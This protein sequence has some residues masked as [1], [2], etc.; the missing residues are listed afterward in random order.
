MINSIWKLQHHYQ[1]QVSSSQSAIAEYC[2]RLCKNGTIKFENKKKE[3]EE[4]VWDIFH[5]NW[6]KQIK[7]ISE[8][9]KIYGISEAN[10]IQ[11]SSLPQEENVKEGLKNISLLF[12]WHKRFVW[13]FVIF[14]I[15]ILLRQRLTRPHTPSCS[16]WRPSWRAGRRGG[17]RRGR[18][19]RRRWP[20]WW[21]ST[22][23]TP[24][25]PSWTTCVESWGKCSS[26][27]KYD[28]NHHTSQKLS[29]LKNFKFNI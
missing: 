3:S 13:T 8:L 18:R 9:R 10:I 20:R 14:S 24:S 17:R 28:R 21:R 4:Y 1:Q 29:S 23:R 16:W 15:V 7:G 25:P 6:M 26:G 12:F 5:A 11:V 27:Y 22:R 19:W 2:I